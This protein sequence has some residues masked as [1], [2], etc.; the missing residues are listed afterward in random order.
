M[1]NI[2]TVPYS[3][4]VPAKKING[5][6]IKRRHI[7]TAGATLKRYKKSGDFVFTPRFPTKH[8]IDKHG[9]GETEI[10]KLVPLATAKL[11]LTVFPKDR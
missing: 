3:I 7:I 1:W 5:W 8:F 9:Y 11:R 10:I 4:S 6:T 2:N